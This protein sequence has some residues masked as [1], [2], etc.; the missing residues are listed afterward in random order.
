MTDQRW[1]KRCRSRWNCGDTA[2][3]FSEAGQQGQ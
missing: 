1:N 2:L 3:Y